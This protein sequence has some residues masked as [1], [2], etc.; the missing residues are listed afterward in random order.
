MHSKRL[1][2]KEFNILRSN[3]KNSNQIILKY[4]YEEKRH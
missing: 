2:P 3:Y 4:I 1:Q